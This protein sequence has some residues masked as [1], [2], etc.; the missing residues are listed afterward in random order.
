MSGDHSAT[1]DYM[2]NDLIHNGYTQYK[3][4]T[5]FTKK[6]TF[7]LSPAVAQNTQGYFRFDIRE[8]NLK[9]CEKQ[10]Y[11]NTIILVR[12][13]E[14]GFIATK[15]SELKKIMTDDYSKIEKS[16]YKVWSFVIEDGFSR[17]RNKKNKNKSISVQIMPRNKLLE[18]LGELE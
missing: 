9:K 16:G 3:N 10:I 8:V 2:K 18:K 7:I 12:I 11:T 1:A 4:T 15:L 13:V 14:H 5:I 6:D 17:I